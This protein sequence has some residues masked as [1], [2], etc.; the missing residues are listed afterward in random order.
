[1]HVLYAC[2]WKDLKLK[3]NVVLYNH[4]SQ[5]T[6]SCSDA[7]EVLRYSTF[8]TSSI[9]AVAPSR[10]LASIAPKEKRAITL[11]EKDEDR[12]RYSF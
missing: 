3:S 12:I 4:K 7:I 10:T 11:I 5:L 8:A 6:P 2:I 1:V 9:D